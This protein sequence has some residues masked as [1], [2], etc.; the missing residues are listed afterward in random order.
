VR[1]SVE[2]GSFAPRSSFAAKYFSHRRWADKVYN[3][4]IVT[5]SEKLYKK[6]GYTT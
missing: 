5:K 3:P 6:P 4:N 1:L 2:G